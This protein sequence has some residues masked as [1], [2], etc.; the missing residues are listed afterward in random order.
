MMFTIGCAL[1]LTDQ[2]VSQKYRRGEKHLERENLTLNVEY[3]SAPL[4]RINI[5]KQFLL[6]FYQ[7]QSL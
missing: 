1:P 4:K 7:Y 6:L 3:V 5:Q 2:K